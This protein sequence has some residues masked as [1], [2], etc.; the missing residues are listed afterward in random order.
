MIVKNSIEAN[1]TGDDT[2][3]FLYD[4]LEQNKDLDALLKVGYT[5]SRFDNIF[6]S[7]NENEFRGI[8]IK[9][10]TKHRSNDL[11]ALPLT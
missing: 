1:I 3:H 11:W 6:K 10:L 2:K 9:T 4:L 8:Q 5:S 7:F